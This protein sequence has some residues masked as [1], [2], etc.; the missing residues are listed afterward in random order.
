MDIVALFD[1]ELREITSNRTYESLSTGELLEKIGDLECFDSPTSFEMTIE[2][3]DGG[4]I[5][6][7]IS[8]IPLKINL[9][10]G[11]EPLLLVYGH[12]LTRIKEME[13]DLRESKKALEEMTIEYYLQ[14]EDILAISAQ[15]EAT[16]SHLEAVLETVPSGVVVTDADGKITIWNREAEE[17]TGYSSLEALGKDL[18]EVFFLK[19]V[20]SSGEYTIERKDHERI[21][22][23]ANQRIMEDENGMV[24]GEVI[25]FVDITEKRL[26]EEE[27]KKRNEYLEKVLDKTPVATITVDEAGRISMINPAARGLLGIEEYEAGKITVSEIFNV[28]VKISDGE[29]FKVNIE[30]KDG[31]V[32]PVL[33]TVSTFEGEGGRCGAVMT[34]TDISDL[35]GIL[36]LPSKEVVEVGE[37]H[38]RIEEGV[39]YLFE[40][41]KPSLIFR[42]FLDG[43]K[44]GREGLCITRMNPKRIRE[45]Y[46]LGNTPIIWLVKNKI[47]SETCLSPNELSLCY[48]MIDNF[49]KQAERGLILIEGVEYLM[50]QNSFSSIHKFFQLIN[51][52]VMPSTSSVLVTLD[53]ATL[54][55]QEYHLIK[56]EMEKIE[57]E[58]V[59]DGEDYIRHTLP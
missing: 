21:V 5:P 37:P 3:R 25:S 46:G 38:Y 30:R 4:K 40:E 35:E 55:T 7:L 13:E 47:P 31:T 59:K 26:L 48:E 23:L 52:S 51:D 28:P 58:E 17:I 54:T 1:G 43:V 41:E 50:T 33:V 15:L 34:L 22:I 29:S 20:G 11:K 49:I 6:Y 8:L 18:G 56:R 2:D 57:V 45:T 19:E 9:N 16:N 27:I 53:P 44:H 10:G 12:D 14:Q 36:V 39:I 42:V 32:I 24:K